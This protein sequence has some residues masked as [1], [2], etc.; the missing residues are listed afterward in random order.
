MTTASIGHLET[1]V[2]TRPEARHS[3]RDRVLLDHGPKHFV[4]SIAEQDFGR[5]FQD[6]QQARRSGGLHEDDEGA[7]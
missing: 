3:K 5:A 2:D 7:E 1:L 4:L 6:E